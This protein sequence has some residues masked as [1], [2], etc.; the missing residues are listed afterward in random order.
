MRV[1]VVLRDDEDRPTMGTVGA[2]AACCLYQ[3]E[4]V[5]A[6]KLADSPSFYSLNS[7]YQFGRI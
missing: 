7:V 1:L 3:L 6:V 5:H 2:V 4:G